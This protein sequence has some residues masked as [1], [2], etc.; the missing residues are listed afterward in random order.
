MKTTNDNIQPFDAITERDLHA[1]VD[2]LLDARRRKKVEAYLE[3]NPEIAEEVQDYIA[4]NRLLAGA[5]KNTE[6]ETIPPRLLSVLNRPVKDIWPAV[7][8]AAA[9]IVLCVLSAGG[10]WLGA[11]QA[12]GP[13]GGDKMAGS[14]LHQIAS[15]TEPHY[16]GAS[17]E[18]LNV[19]TGVQTDPLNWLT[20]KVA[21]EMQAP[22][23]TQAGY[24]LERRRLIMRGKQEFVELKYGNQAGE[25]IKLYM[26]TRWEK[27]PP[28][29]EFARRNGKSIAHWQEGPL[30]Y[31]LTGTLDRKNAAQIADLVRKAM[32]DVPSEA[33]HVQ[34][35]Q[36]LAPQ[37]RQAPQ[38]APKQVGQPP[39][40][41]QNGTNTPP[42]QPLSIPAPA[43]K[44]NAADDFKQ[45]AY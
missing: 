22:N 30:V 4:Y 25:T 24:A 36:I 32:T 31:A 37:Y 19:N 7:M 41:V 43:R 38:Q 9:V 3:R 6:G 10:G 29:I 15:N 1:Y 18:A 35:V 16:D 27:E 45:P 5:Y 40:T 20:Q 33:P 17:V 8:K 44:M 2:G 13:Q 26:K 42:Q 39:G 23:L 21:L 34:N 14:F 28:T 12:K 11:Y